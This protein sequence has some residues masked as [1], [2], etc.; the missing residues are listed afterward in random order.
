MGDLFPQHTQ[1][2]QEGNGGHVV[3]VSEADLATLPWLGF[4]EEQ[5]HYVTMRWLRAP[6]RDRAPAARLMNTDLMAAAAA[7]GVGVAVL[8]CFL[9]DEAAGLSRLSA[10]IEALQ[11]DY[12][13]V[14]HPDLSRNP[15]VRAVADWITTCSRSLE[16]P[17]A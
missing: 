5:E 9:G 11:A 1:R 13:T 17:A 4:V 12:W 7:A 3:L 6:M 8:P 14:I 10:Q 16:L 2:W 15:S